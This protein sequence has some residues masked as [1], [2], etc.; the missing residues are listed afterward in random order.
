MTK[1]VLKGRLLIRQIF[2]KNGF[3]NLLISSLP[4]SKILL[5]RRCNKSYLKVF[6]FDKDSTVSLNLMSF[7]VITFNFF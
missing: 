3:S 6:K 4:M 2:Q 1:I 5:L 7:S